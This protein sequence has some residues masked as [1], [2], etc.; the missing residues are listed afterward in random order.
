VFNLGPRILR[1]FWP[2]AG[3]VYHQR[4]AKS[5]RAGADPGL[6]PRRFQSGDDDYIGHF[7]RCG[8]SLLRAY[9]SEAAGI[10]L[11]RV[12]KWSAPKA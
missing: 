2:S 7:S 12:T 9:L 3:L 1:C 8:D 6:T 5:S 4:F 11:L 10:I